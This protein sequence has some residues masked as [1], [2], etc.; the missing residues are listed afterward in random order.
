[1][2]RHASGHDGKLLSE[3]DE[4]ETVAP[5]GLRHAARP[6]GPPALF[7]GGLIGNGEGGGEKVLD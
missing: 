1:M 5:S 6:H 3:A 7:A 2:H 4:I